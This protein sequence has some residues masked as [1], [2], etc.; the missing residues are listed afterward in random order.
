MPAA[1]FGG[2]ADIMASLAP[3][4]PV[5]QAGTL[6]GNPVAMAAGLKTL[7]L[8]D[9]QDFYTR[10]GEVTREFIEG[11]HAIASRRGIPLAVEHAGGMFGFVF[12]PVTFYYCFSGEGEGNGDGELEAVAAD[13]PFANI[14]LTDNIV[15][16][17]SARY[18][19]NPLV[20]QGPGAGPEVT[21]GG[22]FSDLLRLANYLSKGL[23]FSKEDRDTNI[24][25]IGYVANLLSRNGVVA[26]TAAMPDGTG[27]DK[28]GEA[29]LQ[30][31]G[32]LGVVV[33]QGC[34][35]GAV[36]GLA[37]GRGQHVGERAVA[38]QAAAPRTL[39]QLCGQSL[40]AHQQLDE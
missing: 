7:E 23:G 35:Q 28:F 21:A 27:L 32:D 31:H 19:E 37:G 15:Q 4:G 22:V 26:I 24:R 16:F 5:Y 20:I 25:R 29:L 10:L 6:S 14:N 39:A 17:E 13:H 38:S 40:L 36:L 18:S 30:F 2:R 33:D 12:N 8:L 9:T 11:L 1:A 34:Q 3:D